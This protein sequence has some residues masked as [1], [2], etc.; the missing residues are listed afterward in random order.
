MSNISSIT[1]PPLKL[2][3][4]PYVISTQGITWLLVNNANLMLGVL[5]VIALLKVKVLFLQQGEEDRWERSVEWK[6]RTQR[7]DKR[8]AICVG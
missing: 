8:G 2:C 6:H 3:N 1:V 4:C 5:G 7:E